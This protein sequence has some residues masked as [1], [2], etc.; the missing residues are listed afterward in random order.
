MPTKPLV[1]LPF[2]E[3]YQIID[4]HLLNVGRRT[5][6]ERTAYLLLHLF[7]RAEELGLT[8]GE[9]MQFPFLQLHVA[10]ALGMSLVHTNNTLRRLADSK[11]M[12]W[13]RK[14]FQMLSRERMAEIA[15][16]DFTEKVPRPFI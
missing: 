10:D 8:E 9:N 1:L 16:Y 11:A 14:T 2:W 5:A 7:K 4:E 12:R 15:G 13:G 3:A 6:I